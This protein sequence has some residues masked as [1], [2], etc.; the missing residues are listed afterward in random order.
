MLAPENFSPFL[1]TAMK[2]KWEWGICSNIQFISC[3]CPSLYSWQSL[4]HIPSIP[5]NHKVDKSGSFNEHVLQEISYV[6]CQEASKQPSCIVSGDRGGPHISSCSCVHNE[7]LV[8]AREWGYNGFVCMCILILT[9]TKL[10]QKLTK[11]MARGCSIR[12]I[13]T[14][15]KYLYSNLRIKEAGGHLLE[16]GVFS[17]N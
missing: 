1:H 12:G 14:R 15:K 8:V 11:S 6:C 9:M 5:C 16:G 3:I 2:Q 4:I 17:K 13:Y 10:N 7:T